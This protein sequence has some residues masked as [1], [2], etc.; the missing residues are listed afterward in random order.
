MFDYKLLGK[1]QRKAFLPWP[2]KGKKKSS[3]ETEILDEM[4]YNEILVVKFEP[5]VDV[6]STLSQE[7]WIIFWY[8]VRHSM[9]KQCNRVIPKIE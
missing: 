5:K 7:D 8:F 9:R 6:Y 4:D 1:L 2:K 3:H